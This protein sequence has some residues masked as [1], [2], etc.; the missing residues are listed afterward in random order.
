[1]LGLAITNRVFGAHFVNGL[2]TPLVPDFFEPTADQ[3]CV[4]C[5]GKL[6]TKYS[7]WRGCAPPAQ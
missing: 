4:L 3:I 6:L 1:M 2:A 5:H 7:I